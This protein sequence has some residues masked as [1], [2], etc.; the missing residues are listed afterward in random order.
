[1]THSSPSIVADPLLEKQIPGPA[2]ETDQKPRITE[3]R[4]KYLRQYYQLH[5]EKAREYQ[6][7]YALKHRN[8]AGGEAKA[9][10]TRREVVRMVFNTSDIINSPAEKAARIVD[11]IIKGERTLVG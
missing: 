10:A 9:S 3:A 4:R 8:K 11:L 1:M 7:Q 6:R 2:I 5:K